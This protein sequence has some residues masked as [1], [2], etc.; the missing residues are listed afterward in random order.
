[1][2]I[3][4]LM[5]ILAAGSGAP[6]A[7]SASADELT[8][9]SPRA[10]AAAHLQR[11]LALAGEGERTADERLALLVDVADRAADELGAR[12]SARAVRDAAAAA[13][14]R[15]YV[16]AAEAPRAAADVLARDLARLR[17]DLRFEPVREAELPRG[18]PEP[19]PVLEIRHKSYPA[20]RLARTSMRG[21]FGTAAFWRLFNHIDSN[22]IAMTA[23][24]EMTYEDAGAGVDG[25]AMAFLYGA[26]E[27]G[28]PGARDGV[29]VVDVP[30]M[31][32]VAIGCRGWMTDARMAEMRRELEAWIDRRPEFEA[33]G[34][35][36]AMGYNSPRVP[37]DRSYYE[38]EIP[39]RRVEGT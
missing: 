2:L 4:A 9:P 19:T 23:P 16:G 8:V 30:A 22:D 13:G 35:L 20:Y 29:E 26:P 15:A 31:E 27:I 7:P 24:V 14:W 37:A 1:M 11:G 39:L 17:D 18:F 34:P 25:V 6:T 38:V 28:E 36:R 12:R 3:P 33:A 21:P 5:T 32:T 10:R